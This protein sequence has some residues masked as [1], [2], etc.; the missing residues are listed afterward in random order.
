MLYC[1]CC[2]Q[3][4]L[5]LHITSSILYVQNGEL[6]GVYVRTLYRG[7]IVAEENEAGLALMQYRMTAKEYCMLPAANKKAIDFIQQSGA[8]YLRASRRMV[9]GEGVR[10]RP[11]YIYNTINGAMG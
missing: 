3:A 5:L 8:T 7:M 1:T 2:F 6:R 11:E 4:L 10:W 9:L